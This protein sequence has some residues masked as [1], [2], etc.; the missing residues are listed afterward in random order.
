MP[1]YR[2]PYQDVRHRYRT[3]PTPPT[4]AG[5]Q[6]NNCGYHSDGRTRTAPQVLPDGPLWAVWLVTMTAASLVP[7]S[8]S[9][10][11]KYLTEREAE[12]AALEFLGFTSEEQS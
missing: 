8:A 3:P 5:R 4:K 12:L 7:L 1:R 11:G 10:A 6:A 9:L 2:E